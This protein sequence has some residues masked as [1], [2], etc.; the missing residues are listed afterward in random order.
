MKVERDFIANE[1]DAKI[2]WDYNAATTYTVVNKDEKNQFGEYRGYTVTPGKS[3]L[4]LPLPTDL[5]TPL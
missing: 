2:N 3:T 1:N 5:L 4:A